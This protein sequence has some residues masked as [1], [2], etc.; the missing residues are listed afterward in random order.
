MVCI[1]INLQEWFYVLVGDLLFTMET[2][3]K[4]PQKV[5]E[6]KLLTKALDPKFSMC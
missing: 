1:T 3:T 2:L 5:N 4:G 6:C